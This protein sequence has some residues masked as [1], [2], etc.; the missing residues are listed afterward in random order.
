MAALTASIAI[1]T[2]AT[3]F[4]TP[5]TTDTT[6]TTPHPPEGMVLIP[7]AEFDMGSSE[8]AIDDTFA[9]CKTQSSSCRRELYER[10]RPVR[11]VRVSAF[12]LDR[13]ERS[14]AELAAWLSSAPELRVDSD[15]WAWIGAVRVADL[16]STSSPLRADHG[17]VAVDPHHPEA[18]ALP[19]SYVTNDGARAFCRA[20]GFDLPTE[21]QWERAARGPEGRRFAWGDDLP[22]CD[23]AV[24]ARVEHETCASAGRGPLPAASELLDRTP[25]GVLHLSGNVAEW[26]RDRFAPYPACPQPCVDP[27]VEPTPSTDELRVVRGGNADGLA[28]QLR[29]AGRSQFAARSANRGI[30]FRCAASLPG[31]SR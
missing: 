14:N 8:Q 7:T 23:R 1:S 20:L 27:V 11:R 10:E 26:V 30:G 16:Y 4:S 28:E 3:R 15:G 31:G 13:R 2:I 9:W 18:G 25:E 21:A 24:Y 5:P 29:G 22:T 19:A 17:A 6:A 12:F